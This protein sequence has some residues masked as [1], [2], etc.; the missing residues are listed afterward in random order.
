MLWQASTGMGVK[1]VD[2]GQDIWYVSMI[3]YP[4]KLFTSTLRKLYPPV[5]NLI[6]TVPSIGTENDLSWTLPLPRYDTYKVI[7][8]KAAGTTPPAG[9]TDGTDVPLGSLL[10]T[11]VV[12][13]IIFGSTT[14]YSVFM[15][16]DETHSPTSTAE[17]YSD[18]VSGTAY[19][20]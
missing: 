13:P 10:A 4:F 19:P 15:A 8:R 1:R 12:D 2:T 20:W 6:I 18:A 3:E 16:Y 7:V 14:S 11:S 5:S 17:R 9:P